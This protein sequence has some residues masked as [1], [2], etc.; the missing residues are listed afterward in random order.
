MTFQRIPSTFPTTWRRWSVDFVINVSSNLPAIL[1]RRLKWLSKNFP[2]TLN[3]IFRM[4]PQRLRGNS[5]ATRQAAC[6]RISSDFPST[7]RQM[8]SDFPDTW[9]R[10]A[11][12]PP[13]TFER[14]SCDCPSRFHRGF[15]RPPND[16]PATYSDDDAASPRLLSFEFRMHYAG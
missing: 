15:K 6:H 10:P 11:S 3:I 16:L 2:T 12:V 1:L 9:K 8:T 7:L 4:T 13:T 5:L 14:L